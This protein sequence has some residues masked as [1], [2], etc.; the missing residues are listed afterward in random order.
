M[1]STNSGRS[2]HNW[3][4]NK[5]GYNALHEWVRGRLK[6]ERK[7]LRQNEACKG[8]IELSNFSGKYKR[9]L[10]DWQ[11]LCQKHHREYDKTNKTKKKWNMVG[12]VIYIPLEMYEELRTRAFNERTSISK[13]IREAVK[14]WN[15][16]TKSKRSGPEPLA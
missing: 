6:V 2:N 11:Y 16:K 5:V 13:I 8:I 4:G 12:V 15:K 14:S 3:K 1:K 10:S 9:D 7:C